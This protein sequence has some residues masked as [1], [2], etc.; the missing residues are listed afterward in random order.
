M[1]MNLLIGIS[2]SMDTFSL[3]LIYGNL[4]LNKKEMYELSLIVGAYHFIMPIVGMYI[5]DVINNYINIEHNIIMFLILLIVG[6][7]MIFES[8]KKNKDVKV[9]KKLEMM[10]FGLVVSIDSFSIGIGL[11][12]LTNDYITAPLIFSVIS[13][14]LTLIGLKI[15][16]HINKKVGNISRL[17]GGIILIVLATNYL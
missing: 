12:F 1:L 15:G 8:F 4:N 10:L 16:K 3:S 11:K 2:L 5:G 17:V 6:L 9:M 14:L 7:E 13:T